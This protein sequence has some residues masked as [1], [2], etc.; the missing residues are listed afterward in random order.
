MNNRG[1]EFRFLAEARIFFIS[2]SSRPDPVFNHHP[3]EC[4]WRGFFAYGKAAGP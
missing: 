3:A 4:M 2:E 1:I